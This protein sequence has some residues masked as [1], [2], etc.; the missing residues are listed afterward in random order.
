MGLRW[1]SRVKQV[2]SK[3]HWCGMKWSRDLS[4]FTANFQEV[5]RR[6]DWRRRDI[7]PKRKLYRG[8]RCWAGRMMQNYNSPEQFY[9]LFV[10]PCRSTMRKY[11]LPNFSLLCLI[12]S[13]PFFSP[14]IFLPASLLLMSALALP[15]VILWCFQLIDWIHATSPDSSRMGRGGQTQTH[16]GN[17]VSIQCLALFSE[18]RRGWRWNITS[19]VCYIC[20]E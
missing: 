3:Q 15:L 8:I 12:L 4:L 9:F 13:P 18:R 19:N 14:F 17:E 1:I 16:C 6:E 11:H 5:Q 2:A 10:R 20:C 7:V